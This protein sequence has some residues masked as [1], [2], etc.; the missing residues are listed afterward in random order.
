MKV[1]EDNGSLRKD[2]KT[3]KALTMVGLTFKLL[4]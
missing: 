1:I 2:G 4:V 3:H